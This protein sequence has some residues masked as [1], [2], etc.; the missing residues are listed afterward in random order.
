M[1]ADKVKVDKHILSK[2]RKETG[3]PFS[4]CHDALRATDNS[5]SEALKWLEEQ[6]EKEGWKKAEKLK[7]RVASQGLIGAIVQDNLAAMVEVRTAL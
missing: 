7:G 4:K 1:A 3:H 2:L 6:A 5:F